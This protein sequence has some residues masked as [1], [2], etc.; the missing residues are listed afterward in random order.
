MYRHPDIIHRVNSHLY[1]GK[2]R[3]EFMLADN[4]DALNACFRDTAIIILLGLRY[5]SAYS[6][7]HGT[8]RP[9]LAALRT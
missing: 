5:L 6:W 2:V 4:F 1:L 9:E 7:I 3:L 8:V